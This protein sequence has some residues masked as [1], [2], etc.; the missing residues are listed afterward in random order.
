M[1]YAMTWHDYDS[2]WLL[3]VGQWDI[4]GQNI[5]YRTVSEV[6][7]ARIYFK[8]EFCMCPLYLRSLWI[9]INGSREQQSAIY[10]RVGDRL[11]K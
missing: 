4:C 9:G 2:W 6:A 5:L 11:Q 10:E 8:V 1:E 7:S 3:V